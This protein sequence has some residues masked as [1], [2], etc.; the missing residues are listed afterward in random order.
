MS[1][2]ARFTGTPPT[3]SGYANLGIGSR[4]NIW[5]ALVLVLAVGVCTACG[6][7]SE[8]RSTLSPS[9]I[10]GDSLMSAVSLFEIC[11]VTPL[12]SV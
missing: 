7:S 12:S 9:D 11:A 3:V 1:R 5:K 10:F 6:G 4:M 8:S 2:N